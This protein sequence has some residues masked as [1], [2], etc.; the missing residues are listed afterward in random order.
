[1]FKIDVSTV[2][3]PKNRILAILD[4]NG[5][6]INDYAKAYF[7]HPSFSPDVPSDV[8]HVAIVSLLELGFE[9]GAALPEIMQRIST[10]GFRLC[11]PATGL[12]LRLAWKG[13]PK[14]GNSVLT[15]QH[16]SPDGAVTVLSASLDADDAFPKGLY[17]R[18]VDG[19]L[20]LRGYVC[21]D[22]FKW[23]PEDV[24]ALEV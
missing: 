16:R 3:I 18:S 4:A 24:I 1:M 8:V 19:I 14:S 11:H 10:S 17:L 21:D 23:S 5:V 6:R 9:S 7:A 15:G 2:S 22:L 13:Q 20:W 12:Y